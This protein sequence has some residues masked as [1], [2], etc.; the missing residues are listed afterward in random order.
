A[1]IMSDLGRALARLRRVR[2][3]KQAHVA[4]LLGVSLATVS[5][6]EAGAQAP[7]EEAQRAVERLLAAPVAADAAL[8][9]LVEGAS[10]RTHLICDTS[11]ALLAA[12]PSRAAAWRA[13]SAELIGRSLFR[14]A[15]PEIAAMEGRLPAL[16]WREGALGALAFWT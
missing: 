2:G 15:S 1:R 9:R 4:E 3:M 13:G 5:R 11:H 7:A 10:V 14:Y 6:W 16:G 12:S 8:K